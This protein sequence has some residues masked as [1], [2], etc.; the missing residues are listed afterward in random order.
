MT[1]EDVIKIRDVYRN[2]NPKIPY[3][4]ICDNG[5]LFNDGM[6]GSVILWCDD[7]EVF[8]CVRSNPEGYQA[9]K[10][11]EITCTEYEHIQFIRA[12]VADPIIVKQLLETLNYPKAQQVYEYVC[13]QNYMAAKFTGSTGDQNMTIKSY[14]DQLKDAKKIT[15][16]NGNNGEE[17][18]DLENSE[19]NKDPE[20]IPDPI[21]TPDPDIS[22]DN[23]SGK[24]N[25]DSEN[26]GEPTE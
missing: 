25:A 22:E 9:L 13:K 15:G 18:E 17:S 6:E 14:A 4:I 8:T 23:E 7:L 16:S 1:R 2:S 20:V 26:T 10:P 24:E 3:T 21:P 11:I 19:Q 12:N 5:M